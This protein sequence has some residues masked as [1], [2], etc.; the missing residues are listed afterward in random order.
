[1]LYSHNELTDYEKDCTVFKNF[2]IFRFNPLLCGVLFFAAVL[3]SGCSKSSKKEGKIQIVACLPPIA[4]IASQIGGEYADTFSLLPEGKTPH[5]YSPRPKEIRDAAKA[6][7]LL[8]TGM[9][10]EQRITDA[11]KHRVKV[12]DVS[13]DIPRRHFETAVEHSHS[14]HHH[15]GENCSADSLDPHVWLSHAAAEKIAANIC[16]ALIAVDPSN[17]ENYLAN[18]KAFQ[19]RLAV[20]KT[21]CTA[22]LSK[23]KGRNFYVYHPAFGYFADEFGLKQTPVEINGRELSATQLASVIRTAKEQN[24]KTI[25]VQPQFNPAPAEEL[26][27]KIDGNVAP[28]DPLVYDLLKNFTAVSDAIAAGF[29]GGKK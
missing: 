16:N 23:F 8:S 7:L 5:D 28:L 20:S 1:M 2:T 12:A 11:L 6:Q 26:A 24:V 29:N 3:F 14:H 18:F 13:A 25:F 9:A 21:E 10:F 17:S 15:Y 4:F 22:K 27:R 19:K